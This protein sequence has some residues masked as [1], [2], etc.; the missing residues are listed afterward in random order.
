MRKTLFTAAGIGTLALLSACGH[1]ALGQRGPDEYSVARQPPLIIPPD[2][3][4][5]PP[6]PGAVQANEDS[7]SSQ[8]LQAMFGGPAPRSAVEREAL[9]A[10][11]DDSADPGVRSAV[12]DAD[13]KVV[14]KGSTT[15]DIV[16]AP[17]GDG[18]DARVATPQ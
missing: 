14:D 5:V 1:N 4:L 16:A 18:Q 11:G 7:A 13:T 17:A 2:Y 10:A 9:G 15:R 12:G 3:S 8:A 6:Q